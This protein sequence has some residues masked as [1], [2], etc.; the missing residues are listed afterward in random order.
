M[1]HIKEIVILT[2]LFITPFL[3]SQAQEGARGYE[4]K[5]EELIQKATEQITGYESLIIDF[6]YIV[7]DSGDVLETSQGQTFL[8]GDKYYI[9]VDAYEY[10]SDGETVWTCLKEV[11]EIHVNYTE[12]LEQSLNPVHLLQDFQNHYKSKFI[13]QEEYTGETVSL[14]DAIPNEPQAFHKYRV[15]VK[16]YDNSLAYIK[17]YDRHGG[18]YKISIDEIQK[19]PTIPAEKFSFDESEYQEMDIIDLR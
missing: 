2:L 11:G 15:A 14:I 12:N 9:S 4:E 17:A 6:T 13:R 16:E 5:G 18:T 3:Y 7:E 1:K 19:N 10:T 8:E